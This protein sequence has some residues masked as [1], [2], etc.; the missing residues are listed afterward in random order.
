MLQ[1]IP[2][3]YAASLLAQGEW[4]RKDEASIELARIAQGMALCM[5]DYL[6]MS[7]LGEARHARGKALLYFG[8][9]SSGEGR[10][11]VYKR[12]NLYDP[13]KNLPL[14]KKVFEADGWGGSF[15]GHKWAELCD[16]AMQY[17]TM[18]DVM[19]VDYVVNKQHNS[20]TVFNKTE[21]SKYMDI[22]FLSA[23]ISPEF[24][25]AR[26]AGKFLRPVYLNRLDIRVGRLLSAFGYSLAGAVPLRPYE[27]KPVP[28][29]DRVLSAPKECAAID[30]CFYCSVGSEYMCCECDRKLCDAH[31][32]SCNECGHTFCLRHIHCCDVCGVYLCEE[33]IH[34]GRCSGCYDKQ[35]C[36]SCYEYHYDLISCECGNKSYCDDCVSAHKCETC[37]NEGVTTIL[38]S[39]CEDDHSHSAEDKDKKEEEDDDQE[40]QTQKSPVIEGGS[41]GQSKRKSVADSGTAAVS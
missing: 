24:L 6:F 31:A 25:G 26:R 18:S 12:A 17:R 39:Y 11:A 8:E 16:V 37:D 40:E 19:F 2:S 5:R 28:W 14:L 41:V 4:D 33:H 21:A 7:C 13:V 3:F 36:S 23:G 22:Q 32:P 20:G 30:K 38:C 10:D 1:Y 35:Q 9:L 29:G 27:Y 15:G 34:D